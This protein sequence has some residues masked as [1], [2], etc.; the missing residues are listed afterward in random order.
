MQ[1]IVFIRNSIDF[2]KNFHSYNYQVDKGYL[3]DFKVE[4][5]LNGTN[6]WKL[7]REPIS[8][9]SEPHKPHKI[10]CRPPQLADEIRISTLEYVA[11][12]EIIV[13]GTRKSFFYFGFQSNLAVRSENNHGL[14]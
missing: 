14:G 13:L 5:Q 7:V 2:L 6:G 10:P 3:D 1:F 12:A 9:L 4:L 8:R 11:I